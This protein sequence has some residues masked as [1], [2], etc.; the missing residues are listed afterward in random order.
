MRKEKDMAENKSSVSEAKSYREIGEYWDS[1]DLSEVWNETEE[2]KFEVD[3]QSD[4]FYYAVETSLSSKLHLIA[5]KRGVS[6]ET[7]VNLWLQER[8]NQE[9]VKN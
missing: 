8:V 3:L 4:V 7:L 6:V 9:V 5:E 2:I 1:H